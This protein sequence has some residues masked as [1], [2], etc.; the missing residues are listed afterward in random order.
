MLNQQ[1]YTIMVE[2]KIGEIVNRLNKTREEKYPN[3]REEHEKR[4]REE[5]VELR[6]QQEIEVCTLQ[7]VVQ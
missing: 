6:H 3:L 5:Q 7:C 4:D 2:K 1:V